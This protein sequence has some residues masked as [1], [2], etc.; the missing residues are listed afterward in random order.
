[1]FDDRYDYGEERY[2]ILGIAD[3]RFIVVIFTMRGENIRLI[4]ARRAEPHE[5]RKYHEEDA[6]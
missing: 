5:R 2:A 3:G 4:S 6:S 1:M